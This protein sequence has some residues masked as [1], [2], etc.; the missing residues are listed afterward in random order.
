MTKSNTLVVTNQDQRLASALRYHELA[1]ASAAQ[2]AVAA[3]MAGLELRSLKKDVGHGP[4]EDWFEANFAGKM[5]L[6][7]AQ[8][9]M[10]LAD[11]LKGKT[12]KNDT[13]SF[14]PLLDSAPSKLSEPERKK[15][16]KVITKS[17]DGATVSELYE[18]FGI[19]KRP[20]GAG[21]KGGNK[22]KKGDPK[23]KD[24]TT[25]EVVAEGHRAIVD[26][27]ITTLTELLADTPWNAATREKREELHGLLVD[28][29]TAVNKTLKKSST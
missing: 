3:G 1:G 16:E 24:M 13:V 25:A 4:W 6:R 14:L 28:A 2:M 22:T 15:L 29:A 17:A 18:E 9:Y 20:R 10:A 19:V 11:G 8:R 21:A 23:P 7:T 12:L 5:S 27:L 26:T